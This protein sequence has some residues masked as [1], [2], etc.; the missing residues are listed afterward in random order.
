VSDSDEK[1]ARDKLKRLVPGK[2][3]SRVPWTEIR[4]QLVTSM[5]V[6][7]GALI[8]FIWTSVVQQAFYVAGI[9]TASGITSWGNWFIYV[10]GAFVVTF[11]AV[12]LLLIITRIQ[13]SMAEKHD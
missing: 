3:I 9:I 10:I 7:F 6:A 2:V 8:G 1:S 4:K 11:V 5:G 12:I 13:T